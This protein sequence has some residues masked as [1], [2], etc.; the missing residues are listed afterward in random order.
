MS[1]RDCKEGDGEISTPNDWTS[2]DNVSRDRNGVSDC[3]ARSAD[4]RSS[5]TESRDC[6]GVSGIEEVIAK[7]STWIGISRDCM[8]M[9]GRG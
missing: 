7:V 6:M 9:G 1:V 4:S 5:T 8:K 2:T 3:S